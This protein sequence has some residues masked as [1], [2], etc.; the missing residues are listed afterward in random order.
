MDN[1]LLINQARQL[2]AGLLVKQSISM[3]KNV[4][5]FERLDR[6]ITCAYCRYVRRLNRCS[7]CYQ[8]RNH[9]CIRGVGEKLIPC[10]RHRPH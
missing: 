5:V 2:Y 3:T 9:D 7:T 4:S 6:L 8:H 1:D 10:E